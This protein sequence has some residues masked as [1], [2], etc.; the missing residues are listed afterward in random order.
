MF[1]FTETDARRSL[2]PGSSWVTQ[3]EDVKLLIDVSGG[4]PG[5]FLSQIP[6][7]EEKLTSSMVVGV[8]I[9]LGRWEG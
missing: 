8:D 7:N 4:L 9:L 6:S 2:L 5:V 3:D 1:S